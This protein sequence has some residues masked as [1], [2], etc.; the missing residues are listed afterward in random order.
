MSELE[1]GLL[2]AEI[3][4]EPLPGLTHAEPVYYPCCDIWNV[5]IFDAS[6]DYRDFGSPD[7]WLEFV[8]WHRQRGWKPSTR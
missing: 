2:A 1:A 6:G 5:R 8:R 4:H 7:E 3:G